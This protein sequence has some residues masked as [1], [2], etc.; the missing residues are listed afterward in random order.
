[1]DS[2]NEARA[3]ETAQTEPDHND[4]TE[5]AS[6]DEGDSLVVCDRT[7]PSAWIKSDVSTSVRD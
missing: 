1:M 5:Y 6:Y 4:L 3:V 7:N 2:T